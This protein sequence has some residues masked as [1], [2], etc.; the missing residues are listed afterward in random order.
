MNSG[1]ILWQAEEAR[2]CENLRYMC[3]CS[4]LEIYNEQITD[5]LDPSSVNLQVWHCLLGFSISS[6]VNLNAHQHENNCWN[7]G[8]LR[9][10]VFGAFRSISGAILEITLVIKVTLATT[11]SLSSFKQIMLSDE[12]SSWYPGISWPP[13]KWSLARVWTTKPWRYLW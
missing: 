7:A 2:K 11:C 3:K 1:L 13:C 5:L 9:W 10:L 8:P 6:N 4:F 12:A